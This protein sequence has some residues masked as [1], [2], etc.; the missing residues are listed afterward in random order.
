MIL[1]TI[2]MSDCHPPALERAA[3]AAFAEALG[4]ASTAFRRDECGDPRINGKRGHVNAVSR[5]FLISCVCD[6]RR[7]WTYAKRALSFARVTQDGDEE[8]SFVM[9][10]APTAEEA[11]T[12]RRYLGI[13]KRPELS[14]GHVALLRARAK[15]LATNGRKIL[16]GRSRRPC[17]EGSPPAGFSALAWSASFSTM[18][19]TSATA[20]SNAPAPPFGSICSRGQETVPGW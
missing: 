17:L 14:A 13:A 1:E 8:G 2:A 11:K 6:S 18:R 10:R 16:C 12:I 15:R 5:G 20:P 7:A 3:L 9:D 19:P 4:S